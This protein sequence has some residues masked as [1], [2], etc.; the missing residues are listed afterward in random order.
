M[1]ISYLEAQTGRDNL[2]MRMLMFL[3]HID[4]YGLVFDL[5]DQDR[6]ELK[7]ILKEA[8]RLEGMDD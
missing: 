3:R 8:D 1:P 2:Y 5:N 6:D 7:D 4:H